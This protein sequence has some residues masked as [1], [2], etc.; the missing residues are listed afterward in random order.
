MQS[1]DIESYQVPGSNFTFTAA[2]P[3]VLGHQNQTLVAI[4]VDESGST[5]PFATDLNQALVT[6]VTACQKSPFR[7]NLL[8]RTTAFSTYT[9]GGVRELHGFTPL[10]GFDP[11][12]YPQFR[13]DGGTPLFDASY[14]AIGA[15]VEYGKTLRQNEF[16]VN[17][18]VFIIT[19]G[20][21][22]NSVRT[23]RSIAELKRSIGQ[24]EQLESLVT[25]LIGI[26]TGQCR[27]ELEAFRQEAGFTHFVEVGQA[28]PGNLAKFAQFV[29]QSVSS[30]SQAVNTGGPSQA[31]A[32][33]I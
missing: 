27:S 13:P 22:T 31:I 1:Q 30:T 9:P 8:I 21:N 2:N 16:F 20:V 12:S 5:H 11:K 17:G 24:R 19:D 25:I 29:S 32:A 28:T 23:A 14:E 10:V 26:N 6:A 18:I 4:A 3:E 15:I 7:E 33:T